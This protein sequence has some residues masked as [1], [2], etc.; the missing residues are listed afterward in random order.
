[1]EM[2][3]KAFGDESMNLTQV[4]EWKSPNSPRTRKARQVKSKVESMPIM[5]LHIKET[6]CKEFVLA[7]QTVNSAYYSDVLDEDFAPNF[8]DKRTDCFITTM[9]TLSLPSSPEKI[10]PKTG[11]L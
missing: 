8:D 4:I 3:R 11:R 2:I 7:G 6:V 10:Q 9:Q 1:M 5:F